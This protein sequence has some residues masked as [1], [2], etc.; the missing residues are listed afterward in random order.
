[1]AISRQFVFERSDTTGDVG[2][3]PLWLKVADPVMG[4]AHDMLEH[5]GPSSLSAVEDE[6]LALGAV[7]ALRIEPGVMTRHNIPEHK[8]LANLVSTVLG[9]IVDYQIDAPRAMSSRK[10]ADD[11]SY[12]DDIILAAVPLA[13]EMAFKEHAERDE[14]DLAV[15]RHPALQETVV[16]LLR[17]GYR[18]AQL[19]YADVDLYTLSKCVFTELDSYSRRLVESCMLR[20]GD[21]VSLSVNVHRGTVSCRVN[22]IPGERLGI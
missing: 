3:K 13:F 15:L 11:Y 7:L 21:K 17:K 10:L 1:M 18:K 16:S 6:F 9:E 19:R 4:V 20:E 5:F 12:A 14:D 8:Q 2:L 22:G